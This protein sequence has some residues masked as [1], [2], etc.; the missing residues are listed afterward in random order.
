MISTNGKVKLIDFGQACKMGVKK[1]RVQG[2]PDFITPEQVKLSTV[3]EKTDIYSL[4]ASLYWTLT[5]KK[6]PTYFTVDK[7]D[8]DIV[9]MQKF[10]SPRD[11]RPEIHPDLSEFIMHC[12]RYNP[13]ARPDD[14]LIVLRELEDFARDLT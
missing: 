11:L 1:E 3:D 6:V 12:L 14:M 2:T 8:R 7:A 9:K 5:G 4:A 10:P 13:G